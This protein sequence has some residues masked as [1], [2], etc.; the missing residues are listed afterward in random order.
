MK[1]HTCIFCKLAN[2]EIPTKSIYEDGDF[3]VILDVSPATKGH[4][5]ILPKEHYAD[6]Y[7]LPDRLAGKAM[8][9]AKQLAIHMK[10]KLD[11]DGLNLIQNNGVTA[12]QTVFHYHL[13][14]I[15]RYEDDQQNISWKPGTS[16]EEELSS[17]MK[18]L[19]Y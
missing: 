17:L 9:L 16:T 3:K 15:P 18:L 5:L 19:E 4:I 11:F 14:L 12:G 6:F 10:E 13:H 1:E 2:G 8:Q 7:D